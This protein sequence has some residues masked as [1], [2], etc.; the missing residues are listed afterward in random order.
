MS[1]ATTKPPTAAEPV[2]GPDE[3]HGQGGSYTVVD[4]RRVRDVPEPAADQAAA[5]ADPSPAA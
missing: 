3:Y 2:A 4:G 1:N 5:P